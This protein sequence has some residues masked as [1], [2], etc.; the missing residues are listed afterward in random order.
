VFGN[1]TYYFVTSTGT[2]CRLF[3]EGQQ[4]KLSNDS[5]IINI[6]PTNVTDIITLYDNNID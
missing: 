5:Y 1:V 6:V 4:V 2:N 3:P